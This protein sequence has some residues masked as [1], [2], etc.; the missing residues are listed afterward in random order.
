M[1]E[2]CKSAWG[3]SQGDTEVGHVLEALESIRNSGADSD[4]KSEVVVAAMNLIPRLKAFLESPTR[5]R[6]FRG[7]GTVRQYSQLTV[8]DTAGLGDD[9][10]LKRCVNFFLLN[11]LSTQSKHLPGGG[12]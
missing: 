4:M 6:F 3:R 5:G 11:Q 1:N 12:R 7:K 10:H 2:A 9:M 8:F